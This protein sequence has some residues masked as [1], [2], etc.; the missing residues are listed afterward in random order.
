DIPG[1]KM[2]IGIGT[3]EVAEPPL[4]FKRHKCK[5]PAVRPEHAVNGGQDLRRVTGV[6]KNMVTD[7]H[8]RR[9][10]CELVWS[11]KKLNPMLLD[12]WRQELPDIESNFAPTLERCKIPTQP[13][14]VL[15]DRVFGVDV[16]YKFLSPKTCHP[17]NGTIRDGAFTL[18]IVQALRA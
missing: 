9:D 8:V 12:H 14:P 2:V 15:Q 5:Q 13:H 17:K 10:V 3:I 1:K 6:F 4:F 18:M 16:R 11:G 7:N